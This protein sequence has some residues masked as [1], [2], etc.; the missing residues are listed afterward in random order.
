MKILLVDWTWGI[1]GGPEEFLAGVDRELHNRSIDTRIVQEHTW[2]HLFIETQKNLRWA[3]VI[4][5]FAFPS[6]LMVGLT[7]KPCIWI[8]YDVPEA[9][10]KWYKR[11]AFWWNRK[12]W[13]RPDRKIICSNV[14]DAYSLEVIY[15]RKVDYIFPLA[16]DAE[17][18]SGG[19]RRG[20]D[21]FRI[22]QVGTIL[23]NKNQL[24]TIGIFNE[25]KKRVPHSHLNLVGP[26]IPTG[27]GPAYWN[28][29][30]FRIEKCGLHHSVT[31]P[32]HCPRTLVKNLYYN[33]DVYVNNLRGTG[34]WLA[35]LEALSTGLPVVSSKWFFGWE[36]LHPFAWVGE[37]VLEGLIEVHDNYD[38]YK[39]MAERGSQWIKENLTHRNYVDKLLEVIGED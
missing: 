21:L 2:K 13:T 9:F 8:C 24:E 29:C 30:K 39:K 19:E 3:D 15:R 16:I 35:V 17:F 12:I 1:H 25:F 31:M 32:G 7:R 6:S 34:G 10:Y 11:P 14:T 27:S 28:A 36:Y 26:R 5:C 4:L 37:D 23:R 18:Y 20:S 38:K 22:C 33:S